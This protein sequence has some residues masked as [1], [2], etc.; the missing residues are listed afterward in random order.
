M[1]ERGVMPQKPR[2]IQLPLA[3]KVFL[4]VLAIVYT[5]YLVAL[6]RYLSPVGLISISEHATGENLSVVMQHWTVANMQSATDADEQINN[7]TDLTEQSSDTSAAKAA[8][9]EGQPPAS[10]ES[11]YPLSTVGKI[12]FTNSSGQNFVCSGTAIVSQNQ[13]T[14]DTA[15]HCLYWQNDWTQNVI[16]C[17]L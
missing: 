4:V 13:S 1:K 10:G 12:F 8:Q 11:T 7:T 9:Q 2:L 14:V 5:I 17:P 6:V 15:G 3:G 16:F